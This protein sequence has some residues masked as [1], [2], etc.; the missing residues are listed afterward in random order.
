[1]AGQ[2][3]RAGE[4][5]WLAGFLVL[6]AILRIGGMCSDLWLDEIWS[7]EAVALAWL[8]G[9]RFDRVHACIFAELLSVSFPRIEY[10][11]EAR[12]FSL[13]V[14][15]ALAGWSVLQQYFDRPGWRWAAALWACCA[16]GFL[17]HSTFVHFVVPALIAS[18]ARFWRSGW[19]ELARRVAQLYAAP[20][21]LAAGGYFLLLRGMALGGADLGDLRTV[22]LQ[23]L[24]LSAGGPPDTWLA[25]L[26]AAGLLTGVVGGIVLLRRDLSQGLFF[27]VAAI[28]WPALFAGALSSSP[29][30]PRYLLVAMVFALLVFGHSLAVLWSRGRAGRMIALASLALVVSGNLYNTW[31]F[32]HVGRGGY[33][34]AVRFIVA[35]SATGSISVSSDHDFRNGLVLGFYQR[36]VAGGSRIAYVDGSQ[37]SPQGTGWF[38]AHRT[39]PVQ[40]A[41]DEV[42]DRFGNRYDLRAHFP[43]AGLSGMSWWI[44][45]QIF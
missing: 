9:R 41:P 8:I 45:A 11:T 33:V 26:C 23:T 1:M 14:M 28:V 36:R 15:F 27:L 42:S 29:F 37:V 22:L 39:D 17:S 32:E 2:N 10:A 21:L 24:S 44:Y 34:A 13:A 30:F 6:A 31:S 16:L 7:I 5:R 43:F 40:A 12:G 20:A 38:I 3:P 25:A 18:L 4:L 35:H 19:A